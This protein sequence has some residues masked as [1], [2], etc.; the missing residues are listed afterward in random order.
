MSVYSHP[1]WWSLSTVRATVC[2][3]VSIAVS[4]SA[5][6]GAIALLVDAAVPPGRLVKTHV[7]G[8]KGATSVRAYVQRN[9]RIHYLRLLGADTSKYGTW[10]P[11][12]PNTVRGEPTLQIRYVGSR[13]FQIRYVETRH[14]QIRYVGADTSNYSTL[15]ADTSKY[16]TWESTHPI[17]VRWEPIH[18][19]TVRE[20][21]TR[22]NT[23]P[24]LGR[25][26]K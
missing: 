13:H 16:G 5:G 22:P 6:P 19:N 1:S 9:E 20:E 12:H 25:T 24:T 21:P 14:I 26:S 23:V 17:T 15:G 3:Y 8:W 10:D 18:P 11:T 7:V 4:V 2:M